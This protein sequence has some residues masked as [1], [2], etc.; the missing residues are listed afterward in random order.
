MNIQAEKIELA[1]LIL[2]TDNLNILSEI[3]KF[4]IGE[5]KTD[6][7]ETLSQEQKD[8]ISQGLKEIENGEVVEYNS[9]IE[10]YM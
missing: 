8:D 1:K 5:S 2:E 4:L 6:F 9:F 7:W 10:K 3:K